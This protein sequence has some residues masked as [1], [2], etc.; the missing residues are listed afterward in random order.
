MPKFGLY[1]HGERSNT[2]TIFGWTGPELQGQVFL[3]SGPYKMMSIFMRV[4]LT[5]K[6]EV[7]GRPEEGTEF[8]DL[9]YGGAAD[10]SELQGTILDILEDAFIQTQEIQQA[11]YDRETTTDDELLASYNV[12]DIYVS[13]SG[14]EA[15]VRVELTNVAGQTVSGLLPSINFSRR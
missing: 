7:I 1:L 3:V 15:S 13:S 2:N 4:L 8:I 9:I 5:A 6:G 12:T 14:G 11:A 10:A